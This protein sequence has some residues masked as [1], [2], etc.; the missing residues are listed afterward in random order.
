[1]SREKGK[2]PVWE[3]YD[4]LIQEA[5]QQPHSLEEVGDAFGVSR[6][7]VRQ[8]L[9]E[10]YG[11]AEVAGLISGAALGEKIGASRETVTK[12]RK[13]G[14]IHPVK[15]G[16]KHFYRIEH[17]ESIKELYRQLCTCPECGGA[18]T[19]PARACGGCWQK[20]RWKLLSPGARGRFLV[21]QKR[22][23]REHPEKYK[24]MQK[25]AMAKW[26]RKRSGARFEQTRYEV[27]A[28][29]AGVSLPIGAVVKVQ[30][31]VD[32]S[33]LL[34]DGTLVPWF[35]LRKVEAV[36]EGPSR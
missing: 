2:P 13:S 28:K 1:M 22:W 19:M 35:C 8:L 7:R 32:K 15:V 3:T 26:L 29:R 14:V 12:L 9:K 36:K 17:V 34:E 30:R 31:Q 33:A 23:Q 16:A 6:E 21:A 10:H 25:R 18:K 27:I 20:K 5:R 24:P 11:T 4:G